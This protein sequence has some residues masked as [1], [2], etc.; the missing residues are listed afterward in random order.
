MLNLWESDKPLFRQMMRE[1]RLAH[2]RFQEALKNQRERLLA[3][4]TE[5]EKIENA[6][7]EA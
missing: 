4:F 7:T 6:E 5:L 2:M 1:L 3:L